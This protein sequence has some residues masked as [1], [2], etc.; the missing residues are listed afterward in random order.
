MMSAL[1]RGHLSG[2]IGFVIITINL[3]AVLVGP[4]VVHHGP[5]D[6]VGDV[7]ALPSPDAWLGLDNLGRDLLSRM[8]FGGRTSIG[9]AIMSTVLALVLGV[10]GGLAAVTAPRWVDLFL[11]R[12]VDLLMAVPQLILSLIVLSVLG[13]SIPVLVGTIAVLT[14]TRIFRLSRTVGLGI[15]VQ[16]YVEIARVRGESVSWIIL[17]EILPNAAPPLLAEFGLRFCYTFLFISSL[18]FLGLGVQPP[19]ADWGSMVRENALAINF[20]GLAPLIPATAIAILT[21][22]VN[23]VVDWFVAIYVKPHGD[24]A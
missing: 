3:I 5:A 20:G 6:L 12:G 15:V 22:A 7:W 21:V 4:L 10:F 1:Y 9:L 8:L 16:D 2:A 11:S 19:N 13:T 14:S 24:N 18:S 23:L 17:N